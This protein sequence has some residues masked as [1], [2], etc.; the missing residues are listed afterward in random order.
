MFASPG[1][2][3]GSGD[4][5]AFSSTVNPSATAAMRAIWWSSAVE[6]SLIVEAVIFLT[7]AYQFDANLVGQADRD[8]ASL[9]Q[10]ALAHTVLARAGVGSDARPPLL[11]GDDAGSE[12]P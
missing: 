6:S 4:G 8:L 12:R 2:T 9:L 11:D 10:P 1:F 7:A 3:P 5:I